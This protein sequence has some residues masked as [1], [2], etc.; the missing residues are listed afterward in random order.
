MGKEFDELYFNDRPDL[1]PY[2]I[3]LTKNTMKSDNYSAFD[4]LISIL[5]TG[6]IWGS[7]TKGHI[8]GGNTASCFMDIPFNP[9][10]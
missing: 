7:D 10:K 8:R 5:Q 3:H 9:L 1:T 2:L 4:N 6:Q